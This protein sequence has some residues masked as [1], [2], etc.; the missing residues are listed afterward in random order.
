MRLNQSIS[1]LLSSPPPL[2]LPIS[3]LLLLPPPLSAPP[4]PSLSLMVV[5]RGRGGCV[6]MAC[7]GIRE[8]LWSSSPLCEEGRRRKRRN[9]FGFLGL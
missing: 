4:S 3:L 6:H 8:I 9:K 5:V 2:L 1:P 7:I